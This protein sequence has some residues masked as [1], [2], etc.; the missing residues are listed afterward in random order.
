MGT[1]LLQECGIAILVAEAVGDDGI[2][3]GRWLMV[4][5]S[6]RDGNEREEPK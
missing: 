5:E 2:G 6:E 1:K 4:W 3:C